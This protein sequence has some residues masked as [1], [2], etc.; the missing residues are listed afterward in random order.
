MEPGRTDVF[1]TLVDLAKERL[2]PRDAL[3]PAIAM[4]PAR[5]YSSFSTIWK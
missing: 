3:G 4:L 2:V 1:H 5:H